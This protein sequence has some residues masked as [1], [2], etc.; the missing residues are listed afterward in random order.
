MKF[1]HFTR[2]DGSKIAVAPA[3]VYMIR[4]PLPNEKPAKAVLI[5]SAIKQ[6]VMESVEDACRMIES[7]IE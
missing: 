3:W 1:I 6:Q 4:P 2:P 5:I 7:Q